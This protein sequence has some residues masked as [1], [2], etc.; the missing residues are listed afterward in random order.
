MIR[1]L[2]RVPESMPDERPSKPSTVRK[3]RAMFQD[4]REVRQLLMEPGDRFF[5]VEP[6]KESREITLPEAF[7]LFVE[8]LTGEA[9]FVGEQRLEPFPVLVRRRLATLAEPGA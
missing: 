5:R 6:G 4:G 2:D 3:V 1:W 7:G 8:I 9:G